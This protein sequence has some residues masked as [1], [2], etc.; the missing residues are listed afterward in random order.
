MV[1]TFVQF[2][3]LQYLDRLTHSQFFTDSISWLN[4]SQH[5]NY[6]SS[7]HYNSVELFLNIILKIIETLLHYPL[8]CREF[9]STFLIDNNFL[10]KLIDIADGKLIFLPDN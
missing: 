9:I 7:L 10:D 3:D 1:H 5:H 6:D 2:G 4:L 8:K